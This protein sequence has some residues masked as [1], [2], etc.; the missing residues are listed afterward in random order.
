MKLIKELSFFS[1]LA[2]KTE[3]SSTW[4]P[5]RVF[6]SVR[7]KTVMQK[8]HSLRLLEPFIGKA[9]QA[10][11]L[12]FTL[13]LTILAAFENRFDLIFITSRAGLG[14]FSLFLFLLESRFSNFVIII[15]LTR[16]MLFLIL[17][18]RRFFGYLVMVKLQVWSFKVTLT[19]VQLFSIKFH[20]FPLKH[21]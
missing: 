17:L 12:L 15:S 10:T 8:W 4:N 19:H 6:D 5:W 16:K 21:F 2:W 7:S 20:H 14:S 18:G 1:A 3:T 13:L 11:L 9:R